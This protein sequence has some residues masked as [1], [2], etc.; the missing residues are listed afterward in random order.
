MRN[1]TKHIQNWMIVGI[2][3]RVDNMEDYLIENFG[4]EMKQD[5]FQMEV[6]ESM[7]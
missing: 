7:L 4:K 3:K 2:F 5:I 1:Y 6:R